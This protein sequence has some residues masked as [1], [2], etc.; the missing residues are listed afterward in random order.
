V[1]SAPLPAAQPEAAESRPPEPAQAERLRRAEATAQSAREPA[2]Q[3]ALPLRE[4]APFAA[5]SVQEART[6]QA[7]LERQVDR[8]AASVAAPASVPA[9]P[10]TA[11]AAPAVKPA[12]PAAVMGGTLAAP[13]RASAESVAK[14]ADAAAESPE[15]E[16]ERIARLRSEG[17]HEEADK[18]LA[19][20]RKRYPDF[21]IPAP[22][23]ERVERR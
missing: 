6:R 11:P 10:A 20:F 23:L 13:E 18:A 8:R 5:D 14:R 4:P 16:L 2:A 21:R 22:M 17:R 12:A 9:P 3:K 19:E 15:K 1:A 7:E